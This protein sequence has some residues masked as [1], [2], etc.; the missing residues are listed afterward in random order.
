MVGV[1]QIFGQSSEHDEAWSVC[2]LSGTCCAAEFMLE[3]FH[4]SLFKMD[5][6]W[7]N[8]YLLSTKMVALMWKPLRN[9]SLGRWEI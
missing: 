6:D 1:V 2:D 3:A 7:K 9:W 8:F 4:R 5:I